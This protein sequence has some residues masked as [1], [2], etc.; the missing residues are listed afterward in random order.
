MGTVDKILSEVELPDR[1]EHNCR[2]FIDLAENVH[3]H[4]RE[5]RLVFNVDEY[6]EVAKTF[7]EG[8]VKLKQRVEQGYK[9][10]KNYQT[11]IIGGSQKEPM[12]VEDPHKSYF[13]NRMVI[14]KQAKGVMDD[15]HIHYRDYRLVMKNYET[16]NKFCECVAKAKESLDL[17]MSK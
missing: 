14:E 6:M 5:H 15:I 7:I 12:N 9:V 10:N 8:A 13:N 3:I 2:V 1:D 11:E 16:F 17:L 4:Y